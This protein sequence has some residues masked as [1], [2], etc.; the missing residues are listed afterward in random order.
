MNF[1]CRMV[2]E[3][4]LED[5]SKWRNLDESEWLTW[6]QVSTNGVLYSQMALAALQTPQ[7]AIIIIAHI[8]ILTLSP[9]VH[10]V[11]SN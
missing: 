6:P 3:V 4:I 1:Q 10:I 8:F 5:S 2:G 9:Q 7:R 11:R